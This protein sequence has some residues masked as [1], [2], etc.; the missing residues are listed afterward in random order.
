MQIAIGFDDVNTIISNVDILIEP[1]LNINGLI[2]WIICLKLN[3][4][5]HEIEVS[6]IIDIE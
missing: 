1:I 5:R 4:F 3:L 6:I 2:V